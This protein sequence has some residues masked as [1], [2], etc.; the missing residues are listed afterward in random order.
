MRSCKRLEKRMRPLTLEV[1]EELLW[2]HRDGLIGVCC[3]MLV[4]V[5]AARVRG[6]VSCA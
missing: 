5:G 6:H 3:S 1:W 4:V 2:K